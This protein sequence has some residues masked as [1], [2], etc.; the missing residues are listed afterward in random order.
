MRFRVSDSSLTVMWRA[1][2]ATWFMYAQLAHATAQPSDQTDQ[3]PALWAATQLRQGAPIDFNRRCSQSPDHVSDV[4]WNDACRTLTGEQFAALIQTAPPTT[5]ATVEIRGLHIQGDIDLRGGELSQPLTLQD[6]RVDGTLRLG[7]SRFLKSLTLDGLQVS[8]GIA[9]SSIRVAGSFTVANSEI[10]GVVNLHGAHIDGDA[11]LTGTGFAN[12][13]NLDSAQITGSLFLDNARVAGRMLLSSENVDR[14]SGAKIEQT[15][16]FNR[17]TFVGAILANEVRIGQDINLNSATCG[18]VW[19]VAANIGGFLKLTDG[20]FAGRLQAGNMR[21]GQSVVAAHATFRDDV[22]LD[23]VTT[24]ANIRLDDATFYKQIS[25]TQV[26]VKGQLTAKGAEFRGPVYLTGSQIG[27]RLYLADAKF[28]DTLDAT[29]LDVHG[30]V[31]LSGAALAG[32][33]YMARGRIADSVDFRGSDFSGAVDLTAVN[34]GHDLTLVDLE[35]GKP[36]RPPRW[37]AANSVKN[38]FWLNDARVGSLTDG[39]DAWPPGL[40]FHIDGL[41]YGALADWPLKA[42]ESWLDRGNAEHRPQPYRRMA[43][44]FT[45]VGKRDAALEIQF[46]GRQQDRR[47]ACERQQLAGCIGLA[48]LEFTIGYGI[49]GYAFRVL[50]WVLGLF[51]LGWFVL[52][53]SRV[54]RS[55]GLIWCAGASLDRLLPI[56]ELNPEFKDF[57][58]DPERQRLRGWQ[59]IVLAMIGALGWLLSLF[60]VAALTGLTQSGG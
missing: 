58:N 48:M 28:A 59:L 11:V 42:R 31:D 36:T 7:D 8:G 49:G 34:I 24:L 29:D 3:A 37:P 55:K 41:T 19:L 23:A 25:A 50:W 53:A 38:L 13:V 9:A 56:M 54:V 1:T 27:W 5:H 18:E 57:F 16:F 14:N 2:L 20:T 44:A 46:H 30:R 4:R 47:D 45:F 15:A 12:D 40:H 10:G 22:Y 6:S 35:D 52:L 33:L 43:E 39:Q 32:D 26:D 60:L 51:V 17:T 21:I